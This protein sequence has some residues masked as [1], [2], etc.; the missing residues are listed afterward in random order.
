MKQVYSSR[1]KGGHCKREKVFAKKAIRTEKW[2]RLT[3][4]KPQAL[5]IIN[6]RIEYYKNQ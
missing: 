4:R 2:K 3:R 6:E 5:V 1:P